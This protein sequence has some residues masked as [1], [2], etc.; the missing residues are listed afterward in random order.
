MKIFKQSP[1]GARSEI[2]DFE[3]QAEFI[4]DGSRYRCDF[5]LWEYRAIVEFD[6]R[7]QLTDF[8]ASDHVLERE[9][10]RE[11]ALQNAGWVVFRVDWDMV[12]RRPNDFKRQLTRLLRQRVPTF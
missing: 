5:V 10:Y 2:S 7:L 12:T 8:G 9:R 11:K 3:E 1:I 6:G 4:L